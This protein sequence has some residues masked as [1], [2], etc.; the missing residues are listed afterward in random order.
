MGP[1]SSDRYPYKGQKGEEREGRPNTEA[2]PGETRHV[3]Q[4]HR[5]AEGAER[6]PQSLHRVSALLT[7][8]SQIS[9]LRNRES[10]SS[11]CL[12]TPGLWCVVTAAPGQECSL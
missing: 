8:A 6:A 12:K 4:D 7:L 1:K 10:T 3:P 5:E 9:G 2:E 11:C